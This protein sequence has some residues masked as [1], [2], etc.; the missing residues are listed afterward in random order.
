MGCFELLAWGWSACWRPLAAAGVAAPT[1]NTPDSGN[2]KD[3]APP[4]PDVGPQLPKLAVSPASLNFGE[5]DLNA[6]SPAMSVTVTNTGALVALT[7]IV[8]NSAFAVST[9]TCGV[10]LQVARSQSCSLRSLSAQRTARLLLRTASRF[11]SAVWAGPR[12][13]SRP[14]RRESRRQSWRIRA[15]QSPLR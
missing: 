6:S 10:P 3:A 11:R 15:P 2:P 5:V 9:T 12:G 13:P 1:P 14:Q 8:D 7:P 4:T